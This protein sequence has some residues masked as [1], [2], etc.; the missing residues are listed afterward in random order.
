MRAFVV[1]VFR[2]KVGVDV[3]RVNTDQ[4]GPARLRQVGVF[5]EPGSR[6]AVRSRTT[7]LIRA[8]IRGESWEITS[9]RHRS[10]RLHLRVPPVG[11]KDVSVGDGTWVLTSNVQ[12][13]ICRAA[14][15]SGRCYYS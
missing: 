14:L 13:S 7:V 5:N 6:Q 10:G 11:V 2:G 12:V 1:R 9:P 15:I 8:R 4:I 3:E